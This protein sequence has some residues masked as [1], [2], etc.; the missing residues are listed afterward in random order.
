MGE[1][2]LIFQMFA[3]DSEQWD[4]VGL[5]VKGEMF[6]GAASGSG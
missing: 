2:D 6:S 5:F 4:G 1:R 3:A